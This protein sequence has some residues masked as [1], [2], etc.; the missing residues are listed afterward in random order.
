[1]EYPTECK[2]CGFLGEEEVFIKG[3]LNPLARATDDWTTWCPA[4]W[5]D[6]VVFHMPK[7]D[8]LRAGEER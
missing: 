8:R 5:G 6:N 3:N 2:D 1:M 4:C 7:E